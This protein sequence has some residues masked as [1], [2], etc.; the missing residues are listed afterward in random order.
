MPVATPRD[1]TRWF[2]PVCLIFLVALV[3]SFTETAYAAEDRKPV[4]PGD[5]RYFIL[6]A[7]RNLA[8]FDKEDLGSRGCR[9]LAPLGD[10]RYLARCDGLESSVELDS[11]LVLN[12]ESISPERKLSASARH[13]MESLRPTVTLRVLF[14]PDVT[15]GDAEET[16]VRA[17]ARAKQMFVHAFETPHMLTALVPRSAIPLLQASPSVLSIAGR[18]PRIKSMNAT[19]ASLSSVTP[20]LEAPYGL[21]GRGV[22][23][24]MYDLGGVD[25]THLEYNGRLTG[26]SNEP[27]LSHPTHVAGTLGASG[28]TVEARGMAPAV[29]MHFF[30]ADLDF[31]DRKRADFTTYSVS[32]DNN[33]WGFVHGWDFENS[34]SRH[35]WYGDTLG[36]YDFYTGG[37]DALTR[38]RNTLI[39]YAGGNDNN[40]TGPQSAPFVH[41]HLGADDEIETKKYCFSTIATAQDCPVAP[42]CDVCETTRH[43]G[44]G[45]FGSVGSPSISKNVISVGSVNSS[46]SIASYSSRGPTLDGRIKP[47]L[48]AKGDGLFS[49]A[50]NSRYQTMFGTS[51]AAPVVTG[52][53]V[54]VTEEWRRSMGGAVLSPAILKTLLIAGAEDLGNPGPDYT[55][56]FGLV[57]A[58]SSV[59]LVRDD[60]GNRVRI[61]TG[62]IEQGGRVEIPLSL[63][64]SRNLRVVLGW[65]DPEKLVLFG[66]LSKS[67]TLINDLDLKLVTP[68]G[69][70]ILPYVLD[71][72]SPGTVAARGINVR[73]NTEEIELMAAPAGAY[74]V[75][76]SGSS[77]ASGPQSYAVV[78]SGNFGNAATACRDDNEPNN[79]ESQAIPLLNGQRASASTCVPGDV[80]FY[81]LT[82]NR[83]GAVAIVVSAGD[84]PLRVTLSAA[85]TATV[86]DVSAR[87][88]QTVS[89]PIGTGT[90]QTIADTNVFVK[91]EPVGGVGEDARY[92]ILPTFRF[93]AP[94]RTRATRRR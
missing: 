81:R 74:K 52:I 12:L 72:V 79:S 94:P 91:I 48:V 43:K 20:L 9:V 24:S 8:A 88:S 93:A 40:D 62:S 4:T 25:R 56:G 29:T 37:L 3:S 90:G 14:Q 77:I 42:T 15:V 28:M 55:Y 38:Q 39:V 36:A 2:F 92:S 63:R 66:D 18:P 65:S 23:A 45:P 59:D 71:P 80:D 58:K 34:T 83:S 51:M 89:L 10:R 17:G 50:P 1:C 11:P 22:V 76:V 86:V 54:L 47:D 13:E 44:D 46:K 60:S 87:S 85:G 61:E 70:E 75:V 41:Y 84:A 69:G 19:A 35:V 27:V 16:L 33:S 6:E 82:V 64:A 26:H 5:A 78:T 49:T 57:N 73:D 32:A 7:Q 68:S 53:S 21:S 30:A 31:V 67:P